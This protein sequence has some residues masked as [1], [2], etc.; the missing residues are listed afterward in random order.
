MAFITSLSF[1]IHVNGQQSGTF[2]GGR[3][4]KQG[5]LLSP[6]L[7]V[8]TMEYFSRMMIMVS[9]H[10][11][12]SFHANCKGLKLNHL[13]F[14]TDVLIFCKAHPP[15]LKIIMQSWNEF[16]SCSGLRAYHTKSQLVFGGCLV[17]LQSACTLITNF[18]EGDLPMRYLSIPIVA[19]R[20]SKLECRT[21][22]EKI[23]GKV[24][25]WSIR[26]L[27][28]AGWAQLINS[29]VFRMFN[30]WTSIFILPWEVID[31]INNICRNYLGGGE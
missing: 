31:Q 12:F 15:T 21:L 13:I 11:Q 19:R 3:G 20:L 14:A 16:H 28:F 27:S 26:S 17:A 30:Y 22:A 4:L 18:Q 23:M 10:P 6:L 7:F 29:V 24:K 25:I 9:S 2:Q 1:S 8:L 5:D